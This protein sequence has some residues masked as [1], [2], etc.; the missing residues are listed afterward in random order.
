MARA[1]GIVAAI[2][3]AIFVIAEV[4]LPGFII[5]FYEV[6]YYST[7]GVVAPKTDLINLFLRTPEKLGYWC[8][9]LG[10]FYNWE[11]HLVTKDYNMIFY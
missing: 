11:A 8:P 3:I 7:P 1:L 9:T 2:V 10:R 4:V 6:H 5:G